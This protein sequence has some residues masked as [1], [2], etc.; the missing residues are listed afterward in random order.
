[1]KKIFFLILLSFLWFN[2]IHS[3]YLNNNHL[4]SANKLAEKKI[5]NDN[6]EY[7]ENY[8]L[9]NKILRQESAIIARRIHE[10]SKNIELW[11]LKK[12]ECDNLFNDLLVDLPNDWAC[13]TVES[14]FD[15]N[16]ISRNLNFRPEDNI[17]KSETLILFIKSIWFD[18]EIDFESPVLWQDQVIEYAYSNWIIDKIFVDYNEHAKR[19]WVFN[20]VENILEMHSK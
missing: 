5:I 12:L 3:W 1:M 7:P 17:S 6:F 13:F 11:S 2:Q 9:N 20:L 19:W 16:I 18:F 4:I 8:Y 10:I 14:L 15:L